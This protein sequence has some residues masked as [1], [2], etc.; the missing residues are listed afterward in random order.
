MKPHLKVQL[1]PGVEP[2]LPVPHWQDVLR[3]KSPVPSVFVAAIDHVLARHG[4][5]VWV[6]REYTP[7]GGERFSDDEVASGLNRIYRLIMQR[8]QQIPA[9]L[10]HEITLLPQVEYARI[11][12]V[13][14]A[15]LP[16]PDA[17][18]MS[19]RT[20]EESR[21]AVHLP[22]ARVF[23]DGHPG[24][25]VAVLDTGVDMRHRELREQLLPGRD[26]VDIL[27]GADK[28]FG[29]YLDADDDP[30]DFVGHGTHVAGIV[31]AQGIG[32]PEGIVP[33]CQI[34]PVR[35]LGALIQG[36]RRIG[37]GL[38]ENIN[39]G[40]KYAIDRG[41]AVINMSLGIS[42][43]GG[44]PPHTEMVDYARRK[45]VTIVAASGNDGSGSTRYY[46]G[47]HPYAITVGAVDRSYEVAAFST[48]GD[49][50]SLVAPGTDI[51]SAYLDNGYAFSSG[52]S[53][54]TPFVS[55]GAAMLRSYARERGRG[56]DDHQIK[57]LLRQSADRPGKRL[58]D[59][60]WGYGMLNLVDALRLLEH[61]L[62]SD[63]GRKWP[64]HGSRPQ[65]KPRRQAETAEVA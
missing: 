28:F 4:F 55:G 19:A 42:Q 44:A 2:L 26:F 27:D 6:T 63:G 47:A 38:I 61:K 39:N 30:T 62:S 9:D 12:R 59:A 53:Q 13:G 40:I 34:L 33:H 17:A 36:R 35:V 5:P 21:E 64:T 49:H 7:S 50:V 1:R 8:D 15:D 14:V 52:T 32:M 24:V 31:A 43:E 23:T 11:G 48:Y 65:H 46:P 20:D 51:Y 16:R 37:A 57:D 22:E 58:R 25:I 60:K 10:V 45:G 3:D 18:A 56:V 29:D 54:A 41:A